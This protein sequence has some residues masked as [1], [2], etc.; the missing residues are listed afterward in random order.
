MT[1]EIRIGVVSLGCSK[2]RVDTEQMLAVLTRAGYRITTD[3]GQAQVVIINTCAFIQ[4][5]KEE[6][7][8]AILEIVQQKKGDT[9]PKII[10][11]GCLPQRY[12]QSLS[13][14]I[15]EVDGWVGVNQY[16]MIEEIVK[17]VLNGVYQEEYERISTPSDARVLST[18]KHLAYV[19]IAEGCD[20]RC[21][22]C[23]IPA[24]RGPYRSRPMG[25][26]V[27][28]CKRFSRQGVKEIVLIA[29]DTS[30][31][32]KDLYGDFVLHKLLDRLGKL[33][34]PW[35]RLMYAYPER[36][37]GALLDVMEGTANIIPYLDMPLQHINDDIL[38]R[39]GRV[40]TSETVIA[41]LDRIENRR[42]AFTVRTTFITGFPDES[43]AQHKQLLQF[44]EKRCFD[45]VGVFAYSREDGTRAAD[46][47]GQWDEQ[48]KIQRRDEL[49]ATQQ[50]AVFHA[51]QKQVG[52]EINVLLETVDSHGQGIG[53]TIWQAP[54]VDGVMYI[55]NCRKTDIGMIISARITR[56][57]AYDYWGIQTD[58]TGK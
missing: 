2:N 53:R 39:M 31:Y 26:I 49:L 29:Q 52:C 37:S 46:M 15:P 38:H 48:T 36:I 56:A 16:G 14:E 33:D 18:P 7:I 19:R 30:Y 13:K 10:V 54:E 34:I 51:R 57:D 8:D 4:S 3:I 21:S 22:Y 9:L 5:A 43:E 28:E 40:M 47:D 44:I 45:H 41:L 24:I 1:E 58:D 27:H 23:A 55:N 25:D 6:S 42:T 32:G 50:R 20:H 35:I 11:T 12:R 17:Q